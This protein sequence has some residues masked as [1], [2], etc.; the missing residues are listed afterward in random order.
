[1]YY[2]MEIFLKFVDFIWIDSH[3]KYMYSK[4]EYIFNLTPCNKSSSWEADSHSASREIPCLLW[5]L[6]V[7]YIP[8]SQG[9]TTG[10][11]P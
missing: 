5:N 9:P 8:W 1:M 7:H 6:K 4:L 3:G 11:Y 10:H 2:D